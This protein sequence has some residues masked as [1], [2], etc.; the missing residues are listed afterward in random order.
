[1]YLTY[2]SCAYVPHHTNIC[3]L[4]MWDL[5]GRIWGFRILIYLSLP[6][7]GTQDVCVCEEIWRACVR[8]V[9]RR[10]GVVKWGREGTVRDT[11]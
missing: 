8:T 9:R 4:F 7:L 3:L 2:L 6:K 5:G 1:M 10:H 11:T